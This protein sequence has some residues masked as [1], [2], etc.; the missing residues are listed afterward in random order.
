MIIR[1]YRRIISPILPAS[2]R[3]DPT[4]SSYA[5]ISVGRFGVIRGTWLA[6]CRIS[7]CH[8]FNK[9]GYDPVPEKWEDRKRKWVTRSD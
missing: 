8:P 2:C 5:E 4:C 9:G 6:I 3:F 1:A 7:K